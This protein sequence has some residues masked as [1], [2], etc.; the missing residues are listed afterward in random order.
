MP[1]VPVLPPYSQQVS[2][3]P[4]QRKI[5]DCDGDYEATPIN[6]HPGQ[7]DGADDKPNRSEDDPGDGP[8]CAA[9]P[10]RHGREPNATLRHPSLGWASVQSYMEGKSY[11]LRRAFDL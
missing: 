10:K 7:K 2:V 1:G 4:N 5:D 8:R 9:I 11:S 6:G 3:S